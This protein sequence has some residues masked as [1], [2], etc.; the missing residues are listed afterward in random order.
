MTKA[1]ANGI[2]LNYRTLGEGSEDLILIH[3]L[4]ANIA[5]WSLRLLRPLAERFRVTVYDLR[6]HGYSEMPR[7]GY[8]STEMSFDLIGLMDHIGIESA[9]LAAHSFGGTIALNAAS[10]SPGRVRSVSLID[11]R[12]KAVQP[13]Q[14]L[15]DWPHWQQVKKEFEKLDLHVDAYQEDIGLVLLEKVAEP[16]WQAV[17]QRLAKNALF[18]PFGGWSSG[19]RTA[20]RFLRLLRE[21]ESRAEFHGS[22]GLPLERLKAVDKPVQGIYGGN[23]RCLITGRRLHEIWEH[24]PIHVVADVGHYFPATRPEVV[25]GQTI[26]FID[27]VGSDAAD[28][29]TEVAL[30]TAAGR[31][32]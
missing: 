16:E 12:L 4:A 11:T 28:A 24:C 3:G 29:M 27:A 26:A 7:R 23:S 10:R 6:G 20:K 2:E 13:N 14:R 30:G 1:H 17:R 8:S 25:A 32:S 21:T 22:D 9:H 31:E 15:V 18:V 5:F 19:K